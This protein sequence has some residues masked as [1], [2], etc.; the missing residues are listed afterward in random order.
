MDSISTVDA[1]TPSV[2]G[3]SA[4]PSAYSRSKRAFTTVVFLGALALLYALVLPNIVDIDLWHE[5]SLVR[6]SIHQ[7]HFL[8]TDVFAYTPTVSPVVHHEW[9]AG[10]I[11]YAVLSFA[12]IGGIVALKYVLLTLCAVLCVKAAPRSCDIR[13][14]GPCLLL[15]AVLVRTGFVSTVR[16]Q[17]YTYV[18]VALLLLLIQQ[19]RE[20]R[21]A[22]IPFLLLMTAVWVNVH[23]GVVSGLGIFVL[24]ICESLYA[25]RRVA[26]LFAAFAGMLACLFVTPYG[27]TYISYIVRALTLSRPNIPEWQPLWAFSD[28]WF[29]LPLMSVPV[30]LFIYAAVTRHPR[31]VPGF[32]IL[33]GTAVEGVLHLKMLPLFAITWLCYV[34]SALDETPLGQRVRDMQER[35]FA[36]P[37]TVWLGVLFVSALHAVT[38]GIW[39]PQIVPQL[40]PLDAVQFLKQHNFRG[41]ILVPFRQGAFVSWAMYPNVKVSVDSRYEVAYTDALVDAHF[42]FFRGESGADRLLDDYPPDVV[43][44]P[45]H[46]PALATLEK[47]AWPEVY[48]DPAFVLFVRPVSPADHAKAP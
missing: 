36:I 9:G 12:G 38:G 4:P 25:R 42:R 44:C 21:R 27:T 28:S 24:Y 22:W 45:A 32:F 47:R 31:N 34:P 14:L 43:L 16:A 37:I 40:T 19:D 10:A 15:A 13:V 48:S 20:G 35:Y 11:A 33:L 39:K 7:R 41:N 29:V 46:S 2:Q 30:A 5:M 18:F 1:C 8:T 17:D 23:G 3:A 26:H 6:E